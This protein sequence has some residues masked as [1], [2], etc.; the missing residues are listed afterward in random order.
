MK[1]LTPSIFWIV[2]ELVGLN[3]LAQFT[4]S[5]WGVASWPQLIYAGAIAGILIHW[6]WLIATV[7]T[8]S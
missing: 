3:T 2:A 8:Y 4:I 5:S 6:S 1:L 7:E